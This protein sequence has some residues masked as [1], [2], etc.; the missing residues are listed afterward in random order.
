MTR[1]A[2]FPLFLFGLACGGAP[3][4]ESS[5]AAAADPS[6]GIVT[7][8]EAGREAAGIATAR[9][10]ATVQTDALEAL[11]VVS[12]DERRTARLGAIVD[13]V[14]A[15]VLVQPG[16]RVEAGAVLALILS[17]QIH[18]VWAEYFTAAAHRQEAA[19][20]LDYARTAESRAE[21]LLND[22]A[23][24]EQEF[25]RIRADRVAAEEA[26]AAARA[27]VRRAE[28]DLQHYGLT[29]GPDA[30]PRENEH[31]PVRA[32]FAGAVIKRLVSPGEAVTLGAPLLVVSDLS[33]VWITAEVPEA[34][35]HRLSA[36][37]P[38]EFS[39]T[40]WPDDVFAATLTTIGDVIN[41]ATRRVTVRAEADNAD[42]RLKPEMFSTLTVASGTSREL[43][44]VPAAAVQELAGEPVVFV[45]TG[46]GEFQRRRVVAGAT[47][48][49]DIEIREGLTAGELVVTEGAFL[50][51]SALIGLPEEE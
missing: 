48:D 43:L 33:H 22:R 38:V 34:D 19:A 37:E 3:E 1:A 13:G 25:H 39:V 9:V 49:G 16:D 30:D 36:P 7:M 15:E 23:L 46:P 26:L 4:P 29:P 24:A 6:T 41:P 18:D 14:V 42:G 28:Q 20:E 51:K 31:V 45:E 5:S 12:L 8:T 10:R 35:L 40:A 47:F 21:R 11:G 27:E 17:H 2:L 32:P 50:L 44:V